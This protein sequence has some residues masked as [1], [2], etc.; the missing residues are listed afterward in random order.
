MSKTRKADPGKI[1]PK[2]AYRLIEK[3]ALTYGNSNEYLLAVQCKICSSDYMRFAIDGNCQRC[4]QRS[5]NREHSGVE[6]LRVGGR[7]R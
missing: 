6:V 2:V 7:S 3:Q 1:G 5:V 4:L